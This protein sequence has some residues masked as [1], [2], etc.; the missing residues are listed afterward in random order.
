MTYKLRLLLT[1]AVLYTP[2]VFGG[3]SIAFIPDSQ[4]F[5]SCQSFSGEE[6][7][8]SCAD[9]RRISDDE[10]KEARK[11]EAAE[12]SS[13][14]QKV[15]AQHMGSEAYRALFPKVKSIFWMETNKFLN[16]TGTFAMTAD[17][18]KLPVLRESFDGL[19][20]LILN[21]LG[22]KSSIRS[23]VNLAT[24]ISGHKGHIEAELKHLLGFDSLETLVERLAQEVVLKSMG[25]V[26]E[27]YFS[28]E[29]SLTLSEIANV[30][31][32]VSSEDGRAE[33]LSDKAKNA[34]LK[35]A[36]GYVW[37]E[38]R[39][40]INKV[41]ATSIDAHLAELKVST[42]RVGKEKLDAVTMGL[43]G[44]LL[45]ANGIAGVIP[46]A[47]MWALNHK[48]GATVIEAGYDLFNQSVINGLIEAREMA[49][50]SISKEEIEKFHAGEITVNTT[51]DGDTVVVHSVKE[52]SF[53]GKFLSGAA[54]I[55]AAKA[56]DSVKIG[57]SSMAK[58]FTAWFG[59]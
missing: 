2:S 36:T 14:F 15:L 46:A 18:Q 23:G 41:V 9:W 39:N 25:F 51:D 33:L 21:A 3:S 35:F 56:V 59:Y 13:S 43:T 4:D 34:D 44:G 48:Y 6:P 32:S 58:K 11:I 52:S 42:V 37:Y 40:I 5:K 10:A 24:T 55:T 47:G 31:Q 30:Q 45:A 20:D 49:F 50:F 26:V 16:G 19:F 53:G 57:V 29:G 27:S 1:A 17:G 7:I 28:N 12:K 54:S 8:D 38:L 22:V